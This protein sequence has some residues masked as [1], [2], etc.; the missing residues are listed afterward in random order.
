MVV[1]TG[2]TNFLCVSDAL[3][4]R[5][6]AHIYDSSG[7]RLSSN[8]TERIKILGFHL[9]KKPNADEHVELLRQRFYLHWWILFHLKH[10]GFREQELVKI[11]KTVVR[12]VFDF[13]AVVYHPLLTDN[14]DQ[15]LERLQRLSLIHI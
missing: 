12:P 1:N 5:A 15:L 6:E 9:G 10:H 2:K 14:Q 13:C 11:Y 3:S 7:E 8:G 4:F